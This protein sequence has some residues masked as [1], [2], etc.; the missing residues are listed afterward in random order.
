MSSPNPLLQ[1]RRR[2]IGAWLPVAVAKLILLVYLCPVAAAQIQLD[3]SD[4]VHIGRLD[5][6]YRGTQLQGNG[7]KARLGLTKVPEFLLKTSFPYKK[8]PYPEEILFVDKIS[9]VRFLGGWSPSWRWGEAGDNVKEGDLAYVDDSGRVRYRWHLLKPRLDPYIEM[10]YTQPIIT[11]DNVPYDLAAYESQGAYGQIAPPRDYEEWGR[12]IEELCRELVKLYGFDMVNS[13]SFKIGN[14]V[15]GATRGKKHTF[16]GD[17][18]DFVTMYDYTAAAVKKVLPGAR[19]GP[20]EFAGRI[21]DDGPQAPAVNWVKLAEHCVKGRNPATGRTGSPLEFLSN[22]AYGAA[23]RLQDGRLAGTIDPRW[24][25]RVSLESYANI[26]DRH[27]SLRNIPIYTFQFGILGSEYPN[28]G[29]NEPGGRGAAWTFHVLMGMK[30]ELGERLAGVWH[31]GGAEVFPVEDGQDKFLLFGN[32]WVYAVLDY[33]IGGDTCILRTPNPEGFFAG[34]TCKAAFV[35]K[36]DSY[37][38]VTSV[39]TFDRNIKQR[40][41][42][43]VSIPRE[44]MDLAEGAQLQSLSLTEDNCLYR[45]MKQDLA[46]AGLLKPEYRD[47]GLLASVFAMSGHAGRSYVLRNYAKYEA[48]QIQSLTLKPFDGTLECAED[49][50]R[51]TFQVEPSSVSLIAINHKP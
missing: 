36:Q 30:E 43:S 49:G 26:L 31:W 35:R 7:L 19:F 24:R 27:E 41:E 6:F 33:L 12:F 8:R 37:Y 47:I 44:R 16:D 38:I 1:N 10:G 28:V 45:T 20:A 42:V 5:G 22:S 48:L 13:W 9:I 34:T 50:Y 39:F 18:D 40:Q 25:L 32:G 17:H 11:L 4:H 2:A 15:H 29:T 46:A 14:E 23:W 3:F 21:W 51:L